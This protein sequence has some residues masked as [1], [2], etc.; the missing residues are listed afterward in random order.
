MNRLKEFFGDDAPALMTP[1]RP[2]VGKEQIKNGNGIWRKQMRDR[3]G[4]F[5]PQHARV[6]E[7]SMHDFP[8]C[9]P[10]AT[11]KTL[12]A[13]EIA[14][15]ILFGQCDEKRTV[16]ASEIDF[17]RSAARKDRLEI[18]DLEIILRKILGCAG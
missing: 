4:S 15:R 11:E 16:A 18:E 12:D 5:D 14:L 10:D 1:F 7:I 17:E 6:V 9:A 8:A 3:V 13:E 2:G